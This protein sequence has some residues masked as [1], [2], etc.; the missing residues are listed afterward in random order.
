MRIYT[1]K[2]LDPKLSILFLPPNMRVSK[3]LFRVNALTDS[4]ERVFPSAQ[5][6]PAAQDPAKL[7][8]EPTGGTT[9]WLTV[10]PS[11]VPRS[12]NQD[13][14]SQNCKPIDLTLLPG[15]VLYLPALWFHAVSQTPNLDG[16]CIAVNYWYD[17]DFSGPLY[18]MFN[19]LRHCTMIE[20]GRS[21]EIVLDVD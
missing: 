9:P 12:S 6:T 11:S 20:E 4:A 16:V 13:S 5:W 18:P 14:I 8:L 1:V 15:E 10:D 17:M 19:F 21:E 3:V 7:V 2:L